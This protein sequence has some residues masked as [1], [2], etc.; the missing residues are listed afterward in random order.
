LTDA[1]IS[2]ASTAGTV[3]DG[4]DFTHYLF[5]A[6]TYSIENLHQGC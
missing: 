6:V 5:I 3:L 2:Q 1:D 4:Y